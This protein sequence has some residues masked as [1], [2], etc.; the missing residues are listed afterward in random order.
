M[1][2]QSSTKDLEELLRTLRKDHGLLVLG[3][4][5]ENVRVTWGEL[6]SLSDLPI[7]VEDVVKPGYYKI[8]KGLF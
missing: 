1:Y 2:F 8:E 4:K 3:Y 5:I 6:S 7:G